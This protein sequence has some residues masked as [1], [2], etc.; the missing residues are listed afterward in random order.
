LRLLYALIPSLCNLLALFIAL[1]YPINSAIHEK[2]RYAIA[3]I[4]KGVQ[5]EDP[6]NPGRVI[7]LR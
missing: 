4:K 1:A 5:V 2:I 6:L 3:E 7:S